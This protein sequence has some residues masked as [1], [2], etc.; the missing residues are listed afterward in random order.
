MTV[1][2]PMPVQLAVLTENVRVIDYESDGDAGIRVFAQVTVDPD[3]PAFVGHYPGLPVFPGVCQIDCAHRTVLAAAR[4]EG[5]AP[6][7]TTVSTARFLRV[8]SPCDEIRIETVIAT[9]GTEWHV[10]AALCGKDGLV[11]RVRLRYQLPHGG[12]S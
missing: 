6:R 10:V 12:T 1:A 8:V 7:L 11:A 5:V 3:N 2:E 4:I 9:T